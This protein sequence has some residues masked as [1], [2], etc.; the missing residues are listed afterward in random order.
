MISIFNIIISRQ[1]TK[2]KVSNK[3]KTVISTIN[4]LA[5]LKVLI[6]VRASNA[7]LT[8]DAYNLVIPVISNKNIRCKYLSKGKLITLK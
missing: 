2:I 4:K 1:L 3:I 8:Q 6:D 7:A 5:F